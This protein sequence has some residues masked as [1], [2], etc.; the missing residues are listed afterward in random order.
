MINTFEQTALAQFE[1]TINEKAQNWVGY[2]PS[3]W[4]KKIITDSNELKKYNLSDKAI[5]RIELKEIWRDKNNST[6]KCFLSTMA[7]G[8]MRRKHGRDA[9]HARE[10][11][12]PICNQIRE[13]N[14]TRKEGFKEFRT[15]RLER[16]L[17]G[18]GPAYFTKILFF[19]LPKENAYILDQWTARSTHILTNQR[20]WPSVSKPTKNRVY[21]TDHV[22]ENEYEDYC[23]IVE[24]LAKIMRSND[25]SK[26]EERMFGVGGRNPSQWRKYVMK[27]WEKLPK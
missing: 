24:K 12:L 14:L 21:V 7:W 15:L 5:N 17:R 13:G 4:A 10:N 3:C 6:E 2:K 18:M 23:L 27:N 8:G 9:W 26:I 16:K 25:N 11:W 22:T 19:A 1:Q 20:I